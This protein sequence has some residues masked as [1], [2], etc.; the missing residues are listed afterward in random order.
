MVSNIKNTPS[1]S[2]GKAHLASIVEMDMGIN[3]KLSDQALT[4]GVGYYDPQFILKKSPRYAP[5]NE[6]R[7]LYESKVTT[8]RRLPLMHEDD[9]NLIKPKKYGVW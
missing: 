6:R 4:P 8:V 3:K 2:I 7:F 9:I 1:Y 5:T